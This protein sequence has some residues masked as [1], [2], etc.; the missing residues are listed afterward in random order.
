MNE[1]MPPDP[2]NPASESWQLRLIE[3]FIFAASEPVS[4]EALKEHVAVGAD[5]AHLLE[6]L[7]TQYQYRGI[8]LVKTGGGWIF[9]TAVDLAPALTKYRTEER[10]LSRAALETLAIIAWHQPV[11]RAEIEDIRGVSVSRGTID[12]LMEA[13]WV[14]TG[15]RRQ[16]PGRPLTFGTTDGFLAHFGLASVKDLPGMEEMRAMG[17][18]DAGPLLPNFASGDEGIP[19]DEADEDE[20]LRDE[21]G[22]VLL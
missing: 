20:V 10:R 6:E 9:R 13:G 12:V 19:S 7:V 21:D 2:D 18:L 15:P 16:V 4:E 5:I 17:L 14:R 3:A 11:T 1:S 8:N 22:A